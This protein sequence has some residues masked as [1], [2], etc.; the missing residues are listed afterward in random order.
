LK[1]LTDQQLLLDYAEHRSEA[2]F[3]ELVRRHIDLVYSAA[4]R[5]VCSAHHA[6]DVT[7]GAFMV[8]AREAGRLSHRVVLS[9]WL[10]T[11]ARNLATKVVRSEVRRR[12]REQ[13]VAPM[14]RLVSSEPDSAWAC[15]APHF[16]EAMGQLSEPDRDALLL[17]YFERKSA[18]EMAA[19]LGVSEHAAQ[20][21]VGRAVERMRAFFAKRGITIGASGLTVAISANA[22]QVAPLGLASAVSSVVAGAGT[23]LQTSTLIAATTKTMAMTTLQKATVAVTLVLAAG[24]GI[25]QAYR[26][27]DFQGQL[28][29]VLQQR[30]ALNER[31]QHLQEE[32]DQVI[33]NLAAVR[34]EVGQF[35]GV[36]PEL[37]RLRAEVT[38]LR[39]DAQAWAQWKAAQASDPTGTTA[40]S[41]LVRVDQLRKRAETMPDKTIPELKLLTDREWLDS[42]KD[43]SQLETDA[44]FRQALGKLR[45]S[46]KEAFGQ[47]ARRALTKYLEANDG[48]LPADWSQLK[49]YFQTPVDDAILQ[50][51]ALAQSGKLADVQSDAF[52]VSEKAPPVDAEFDSRYEFNM[53]GTRS[54]SVNPINNAIEE[55]A[56]QFAE[57]NNGLLPKEPSQ[58]APY[59]NTP[60]EPAEVQKILSRI[61]PGV[62]TL[63]QLKAVGTLEK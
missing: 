30:N 22:V 57:A 29:A 32:R 19:L 59:L 46:A 12:T 21:R 58:L 33:T 38:K 53:N 39:G 35:R 9:G 15:I 13:E 20:K 28:Q 11:T 41:W 26:A 51:Y 5:T 43:F 23:T 17:R 60:V 16:D 7:Q 4:L 50:R 49:P 8:L 63:D 24:A 25:H 42:V 1:D 52:L 40:R 48:A 56:L 14:N 55:A 18:H 3:A 47:L 10:Y 6:E 62:S 34:T 45:N 37:L 31:L 44:D 27:S 54:S 61:P 2:A 36:P